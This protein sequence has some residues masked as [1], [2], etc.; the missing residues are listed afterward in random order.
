MKNVKL[1]NLTGH[2]VSVVLPS[3]SVYT[4][5]KSQDVAIVEEIRNFVESVIVAGE[6]VPVYINNYGDVR[7]LPDQQDGVYYIVPLKVAKAAQHR[8]DLLVV[9]N[10][11]KNERGYIVGCKSFS[12]INLV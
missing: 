2:D 11:Q 7:G 10:V 6:E 9:D 8:S 4:I 12:K 1:V 3:G 5:P